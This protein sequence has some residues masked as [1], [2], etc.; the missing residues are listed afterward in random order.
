MRQIQTS[1]VPGAEYEIIFDPT[2]GYRITGDL[3]RRLR[4]VAR[5]MERPMAELVREA[6]SDYLASP[7]RVR[8]H[9]RIEQG[10][11]VAGDETHG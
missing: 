11:V 1:F 2:Y 8:E 9:R 6:L 7:R 10:G 4:S 5:E 3:A